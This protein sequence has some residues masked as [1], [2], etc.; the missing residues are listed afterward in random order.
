MQAPLELSTKNRSQVVKNLWPLYVHDLSDFDSHPVN[1]HGVLG[2]GDEVRTLGEQG[3][4]LAAWWR[5]PEHLFP[6]LILTA[7][8]PVG[9]NLIATG[10][11]VPESID[12]DFVVHEFFVLRAHR[13]GGLARAAAHA[14]FDTHRGRW[15]VVTY[16][17]HARA[18]AFWR[19]T[20]D[21]HTGGDFVER[22]GPHHWGQKVI[23]EFDNRG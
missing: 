4:T 2:A 14:G 22:E 21:E 6:Y 7:G 17:S 15:Q 3:E 8:K 20:I 19:R 5:N 11:Y 13:G 16:P 18:I 12:A 9:F 23:W 10:P 1:G